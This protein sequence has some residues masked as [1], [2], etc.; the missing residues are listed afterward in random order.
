MKDSLNSVDTKVSD[1]VRDQLWMKVCG[2]VKRQVIDQVREQVRMQVYW[3][4][5]DQVNV[6]VDE[7]LMALLSLYT[8]PDEFNNSLTL[9]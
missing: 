6:R 8:L 2:Q 3:Q 7:Q 4:V 9:R 5:Y 1:Y